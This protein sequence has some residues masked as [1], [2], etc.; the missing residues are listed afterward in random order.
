MDVQMSTSSQIDARSALTQLRSTIASLGAFRRS[1]DDDSVEP[2][3]TDDTC[4]TETAELDQELDIAPSVDDVPGLDVEQGSGESIKLSPSRT[5][6]LSS[7]LST[8][9]E[10]SAVDAVPE[11]VCSVENIALAEDVVSSGDEHGGESVVIRQANKQARIM[12]VDDEPLNVMT[13]KQHL[14]Q[15][16][17]TKFITTSNATEVLRLVREESPDV[18][19]LDINMPEVNG[20]DIMLVMGL[21]P[22]LQHIPVL[23]LTAT[24][25]PQVRKKALNLGASDFL[26]KP[27]EPDELLPRVR[28]AVILKQ[29][30]DMVSGEAARLEQQVERRTR[31]LEAT[32]QH[33]ILSLARAAEHRDND[34]GNHVLRV[35]RYTTI[36]A[37]ELGYPSKRLAMLEQAAQLHDVGKIGIPDAILFKPGKLDPDEY[38]LI[39]KHCALGKQIIEPISEKDWAVLKTHTR[40]GESMLH[41]RTSPLLMLA[42]RIAQTHH[43]K[44]DGSGYPL[45][46]SG[47]DIPL[48]GRI[49]AVADIF[50]ALSSSRPYKKAFSRDQCFA[51]LES[52][53][54]QHFD[55]DILDAFFN[56]S[57]HIIEIQ[58]QLMDAEPRI[59]GERYISD[60][61][62]PASS[63]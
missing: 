19:L 18:V 62:S 51:I 25:D 38:N 37:E 35:G 11:R 53:R 12:I 48:E 31:Q 50:D 4:A 1:S 33:L 52:G 34:T 3:A 45:G 47:K 9:D 24:T 17:Y 15:E 22:A 21:D 55:P 2:Q 29:H 40:R 63:D 58:M 46:L 20:L 28:N 27:I 30:F 54:G 61:L 57:E 23:V 16:G 32:R 10:F 44:W 13:F 41:D 60:D 56:C 7:S 26:S 5:F 59:T 8:T 39:K 36:I 14:K 42:A 43:E 49:V 6:E